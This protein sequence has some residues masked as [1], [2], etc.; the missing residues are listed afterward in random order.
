MLFGQN[1][2]VVGTVPKL[3]GDGDRDGSEEVVESSACTLS[4]KDRI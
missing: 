4:G 2:D 1:G 3:G